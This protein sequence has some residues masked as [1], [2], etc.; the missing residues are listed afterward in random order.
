MKKIIFLSVLSALALLVINSCIKHPAQT[1]N[2]QVSSNTDLTINEFCAHSPFY[3]D[4]DGG[5]PA[6]SNH[7]IEIYNP[8]DTAIDFTKNHNYFLTQDSTQI[9]AASMYMLDTFSIASKG[10]ILVMTDSPVLA[11]VTHMHANF[12]TS[13]SGGWLGFYKLVNGSFVALT[14]HSF[15]APGK[16]V[17]EGRYPDNGT[18]WYD[19]TVPTPLGPNSQNGGISQAA[20][21]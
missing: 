6:V 19:F 16:N 13:K 1:V 20:N 17:S 18:V 8:G 12:H 2:T 21:Q 10:Y 3:L 7:W 5:Q 4:S 15:A 14:K 11:N 9:N